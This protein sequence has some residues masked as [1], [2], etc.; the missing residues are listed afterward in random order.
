MQ[1]PQQCQCTLVYMQ[2]LLV[3]T[4][5]ITRL[6]RA[7]ETKEY[8]QV[9]GQDPSSH[10]PAQKNEPSMIWSLFVER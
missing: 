1:E 4:C 8:L 6:V 9:E 3:M 2:T 7:R 10:L 5:D